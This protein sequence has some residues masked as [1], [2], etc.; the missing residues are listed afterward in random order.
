MRA[1]GRK[2]AIRH[3]EVG[4]GPQS[5]RTADP[6]V[7]CTLRKLSVVLK[8][9]GRK[10]PR[11]SLCFSQKPSW[12]FLSP[13]GQK[14]AAGGLVTKSCPN[15]AAPWTTAH[16]APLSSVHGISQEEHWSGLPFPSPGDLLDPEM[17]LGSLA[18]QE[19][20]LPTEPPGKPQQIM[21]QMNS[22]TPVPKKEDLAPPFYFSEHDAKLK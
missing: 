22:V 21:L 11:C 6:C 16:Q 14:S 4:A 9:Q 19:D 8:I 15:L 1:E 13:T 7:R 3:N 12:S 18:L 5:K 17:E 10:S 20:S 2:S